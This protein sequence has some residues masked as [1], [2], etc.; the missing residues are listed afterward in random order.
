MGDAQIVSHFLCFLFF[1]NYYHTAYLLKT[2]FNYRDA[3]MRTMAS[4]ISGVSIA[5]ST[6]CWG[7]DIKAARHCPLWDKG[8]WRGKCFHLMTSS[9]IFDP[10]AVRPCRHQPC[11]GMF[12]IIKQITLHNKWC[13]IEGIN[14]LGFRKP[15]F[16]VPDYYTTKIMKMIHY[17][18]VTW[19]SWR[20]G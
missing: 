7:A 5:C 20:L 13:H 4:Q 6:V 12:L 19:A 11:V 2:T 3:I 17:N 10:G 1:G 9:C 14:K 18:N 15:C 8:Q 16:K